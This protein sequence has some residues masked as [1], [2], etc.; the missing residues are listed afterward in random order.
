M[1]SG[2]T[3]VTHPCSLL[4]EIEKKNYRREE[5]RQRDTQLKRKVRMS[6]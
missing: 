2:N 6:R 5:L 3:E 1:G 4:A